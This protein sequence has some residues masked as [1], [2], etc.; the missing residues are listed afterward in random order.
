VNAHVQRLVSVFKMAT[1]LEECATEKQR[2]FVL[3]FFCGERNSMQ[4]I[5]IKKCFLFKVGRVCR[6]KWVHNC[7]INVGNISLMVETEVAETTV[8]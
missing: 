6:V 7:W 8:K 2:S 5:F 1:M 4:R 3:L